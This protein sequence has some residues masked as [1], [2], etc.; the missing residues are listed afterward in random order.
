MGVLQTPLCAS[1]PDGCLRD[2]AMRLLLFSRNNN[3]VHEDSGHIMAN[4]SP[5]DSM[6]LYLNSRTS[7]AYDIR[8]WNATNPI[9]DPTW[10][11]QFEYLANIVYALII[12]HF[13]KLLLTICCIIAAVFTVTL[14][15][16]IDLFGLLEPRSYA[17]YTAIG[18][19]ILDSTH[20]FIGLIRLA[21]PFLTGL[22]LARIGRFIKIPHGFIWCSM[23]ILAFTLMPRLGGNDRMWLN[24][25]YEAFTIIILFPIILC[26]GAGSKIR[27]PRI[28][29][30]CNFLGHISY[31]LYITHIAFIYM[32]Y[33]FR[34][35]HPD[36]PVSMI[37]CVC[38]G[39]YIA[40]IG[41]AY[42]SLKL[43]DIP[44]R[45][46]LKRHWLHKPFTNK[47]TDK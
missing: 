19:W 20:I 16:N 13:S 30:V 3:N 15:M 36:A 12:R 28:Q 27:N 7:P 6:V 14:T 29:K 4:V 33:T 25:L 44:L 18:G 43:Y 8:G 39:L 21:C 42:A 26:I 34:D 31:P 46:W 11:L 22:L 1:S 32:L 2:A 47:N 35:S 17:A 5:D 45:E 37:I 9:N 24:G 38:V 41:T 10:T 23:L 40:A